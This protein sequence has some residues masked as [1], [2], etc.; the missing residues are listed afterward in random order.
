MKT[1]QINWNLLK[2]I[3]DELICTQFE[4]FNIKFGVLMNSRFHA[5]E[6]TW[7]V[8]DIDYDYDMS[9]VYENFYIDSNFKQLDKGLCMIQ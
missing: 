8:Q 3:E 9:F 1:K 2:K 4:G 7:K 5:I 6:T